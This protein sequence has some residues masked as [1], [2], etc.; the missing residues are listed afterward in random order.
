MSVATVNTALRFLREEMTDELFPERQ[1]R[2]GE[3]RALR[4]H[5]YFDLMQNFGTFVYFDES[6][7]PIEV[8]QIPNSFDEDYLW[9]VIEEDLEAAIAVLPQ[10]SEDLG[11]FN[12]IS[13]YAYLTKVQIFQEKWNE[14]IASANEV[15]NSG[16][17]RLVQDIERL[18]SEPGYGNPENVFAVQFSVDDGSEFGNVNFGTLLNSPSAGGDDPRHPY[19]NGDDFNKPSQNLV[20]AFKVGE[21]GL[22]L[23]ESYNEDN[24]DP[25]DLLDPRLD[26]AIGRPG[27]TWKQWTEIP[28]LE[29][30]SRDPGTYGLYVHKK[31][32]ISPYSS[33]QANIQA[34]PW[35]LG[36]LDFAIIKYSE[37]LLWKAE[38]LIETGNLDAARE[39]INQVRDRAKNSPNVKDFE[40]PQ[41]DA[42]N[43]HIEL[44]PSEG[45]DLET[46]TR[47]LRFERRLELALEGRYYYD[48]VRWGIAEEE[49]NEYLEDERTERSYLQG[50][51]FSRDKAYLPVPQVEIDIT[52][53]VLQQRPEY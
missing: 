47:A 10:T 5:F 28:Q 6:I 40:N 17:Y 20:N 8:E 13:A 18:Y 19:L 12:Q 49:I 42:A 23:F 27:I 41:M 30:W 14:A 1:Q 38:A 3:M 52:G 9:G 36:A 48:L 25:N 26:H 4:A 43:Y 29:R 21:D 46:A 39:L 7:P 37:V 34:F 51:N 53:G 44:Y 24:V 50:I 33:L 2:I 15:I 22:P 35:A 45:W 11:R 32:I 31:N 16:H